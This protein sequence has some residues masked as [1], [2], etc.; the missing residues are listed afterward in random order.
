MGNRTHPGSEHL[1]R[2]GHREAEVHQLPPPDPTESEGGAALQEVGSPT[3]QP[4]QLVLF[5]LSSSSGVI[6]LTQVNNLL[7]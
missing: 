5:L 2:V 4:M 6:C 3:D 1:V 7:F